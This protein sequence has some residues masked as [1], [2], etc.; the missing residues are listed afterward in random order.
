MDSSWLA[1]PSPETITSYSELLKAV[2]WPLVVL[3]ICLVYKAEIKSAITR[4]KKTKL[5]FAEAEFE[6]EVR[7][8]G[9]DTKD[10][11]AS[12]MGH[13]VS[14]TRDAAARSDDQAA[15][16]TGEGEVDQPRPVREEFEGRMP[17]WMVDTVDDM[18]ADDVERKTLE[19]TATSPTAGIMFLARELE[20]SINNL[21]NLLLDR[22]WLDKNATR[23]SVISKALLLED[24]GTLPPAFVE[25]LRKFWKIRNGVVHEGLGDAQSVASA[26][27]SGIFLL[28]F[29]RDVHSSVLIL[30]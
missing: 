14:S 29:L 28:R 27:D 6:H 9:E 26:I 16:A 2:L 25:S 8:L 23:T 19:L 20:I 10:F 1:W 4:I 24:R 5:G 12:K 11:A 18:A 21:S 22:E 15:T 17:R 7:T 13:V 3:T 30:D